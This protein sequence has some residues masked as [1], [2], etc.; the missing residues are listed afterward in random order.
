MYRAL[1]LMSKALWSLSLPAAWTAILLALAL[2]ARRRA[3]AVP[4]ALLAFAPW[5]ALSF[6]PVVN[7]LDR[8]VVA[9]GRTTMKPRLQYDV[10]IVLGGN[11]C[12]IRAG[13][14]VLRTGRARYLLYSGA[15]GEA[16]IVEVRSQLMGH[17]VPDDRIIIEARSR[18]TR[19]NALESSR[20]I[21]ARG[22][23][24]LLLVTGA[25]HVERATGCFHQLGLRPDVLP[26][27]ELPQVI[28]GTW[29]RAIALEHSAELAH[30]ILA[31]FAYRV[32][33][34]TAD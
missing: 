2:S 29:P 18:N 9:S 34:Y 22:W 25:A 28:P 5:G 26:V 8:V 33:G 3:V 1:L 6:P 11:P 15:L 24:S 10:A 31:R 27:A 20:I 21:A 12:R 30:E 23:R 32:L 7:A 17:G 4:L 13:A 16:E 14:D 19:E